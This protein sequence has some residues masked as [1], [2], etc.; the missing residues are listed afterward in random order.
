MID[1]AKN[2]IDLIRYYESNVNINDNITSLF[3]VLFDGSNS[4]P[5]F[6]SMS[7][8]KKELTEQGPLGSDFYKEAVAPY[9]DLDKYLSYSDF[10]GS[11]SSISVIN[12]D[13]YLSGDDANAVSDQTLLECFV[14]RLHKMD[15]LELD[16]FQTGD[17]N[18]LRGLLFRYRSKKGSIYCYQM[19]RPMWLARSNLILLDSDRLRFYSDK[20]I[21]IGKSFDFIIFKDDIFCKDVSVL[22]GQFNFREIIKCRASKSYAMIEGLLAVQ[23]SK[24][25]KDDWAVKKLARISDSPVLKLD[26]SEIRK[27]SKKIPS[28]SRLQFDSEDKIVINN[29]S[30]LR[31]AIK[32]LSDDFLRSPITDVTY[33]STS[34]KIVA[35]V[36]P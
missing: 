18:R 31:I 21:K 29:K 26:P 36:K 4:D 20:S 8:S 34:K 7:F 27:R 13:F 2:L 35:A 16:S 17:L 12:R 1:S 23:K 30:D 11:N 15:D 25:M 5:I 22:E 10:S 9:S 28:Y 3:A 32:L 33:D 24:V 19:L 6:Q 14:D